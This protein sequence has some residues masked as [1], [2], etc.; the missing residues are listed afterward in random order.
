MRMNKSKITKLVI[1]LSLIITTIFTT[2]CSTHGKEDVANVKYEFCA[3][4]Y[5]YSASEAYNMFYYAVNQST[6]TG[7][8]SDTK[9][10]VINGSGFKN[11][12]NPSDDNKGTWI[13]DGFYYFKNNDYNVGTYTLNLYVNSSNIQYQKHINW[14]NFPQWQSKPSFYINTVDT[15]NPY[16]QVNFSGITTNYDKSA[17]TVKYR[18]KLYVYD[19]NSTIVRLYGQTAPTS[20][21]NSITYSFGLNKFSQSI[22]LIPVLVAEMIDNNLRISKVLFYVGDKSFSL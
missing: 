10:N 18:L 14:E 2:G 4:K 19:K 17:Y 20:N 9:G 15:A 5:F 7:S 16:V 8:V 11:A 1:L 21:Q 12:I 13:S 6:V 22:N 3:G